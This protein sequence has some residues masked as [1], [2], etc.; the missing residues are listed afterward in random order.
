MT[1]TAPRSHKLGKWISAVPSI[2]GC[3]WLLMYI[4]QLPTGTKPMQETF[5]PGFWSRGSTK[6]SLSC[7]TSML[8]N[9]C[10]PWWL[11][12]L[13]VYY[14]REASNPNCRRACFSLLE[15]FLSNF[16]KNGVSKPEAPHFEHNTLVR[17]Q[18]FPKTQRRSNNSAVVFI[19]HTVVELQRPQ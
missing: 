6:S 2:L 17:L 16:K 14:T 11:R 9:K 19:P 4:Q 5:D 10:L 12:W 15:S 3:F 8:R 7:P 18:S 1:V 13:R